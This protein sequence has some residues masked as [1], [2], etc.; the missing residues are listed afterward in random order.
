MATQKTRLIHGGPRRQQAADRAAGPVPPTSRESLFILE[1]GCQDPHTVW[2]IWSQTSHESDPYWSPG[3]AKKKEDANLPEEVFICENE[4]TCFNLLQNQSWGDESTSGWRLWCPV[5]T[6]E[7]LRVSFQVSMP[8]GLQF[9]LS[10]FHGRWFCFTLIFL[11]LSH[12]GDGTREQKHQDEWANPA[13]LLL[14]VPGG[15][16]PEIFLEWACIP[17]H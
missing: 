7:K 13:F 6:S 2:L 9:K 14:W 15:L 10:S 17:V 1:L 16:L 3:N 4:T 5:A 11:V 8:L 12:F